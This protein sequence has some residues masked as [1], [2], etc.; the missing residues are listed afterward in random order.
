MALTVVPLSPGCRAGS[1]GGR[2]STFSWENPRGVDSSGG[3][4]RRE[5]AAPLLPKSPGQLLLLLFLPGS[6]HEAPSFPFLQ[7]IPAFI[8]LQAQ[9]CTIQDVPQ[10][11]QV[12]LDSSLT[13]LYHIPLWM[14]Q[15]PSDKCAFYFAS[16]QPVS[17]SLHC[18]CSL[19]Q[20]RPKSHCFASSWIVP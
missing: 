4:G 20:L 9:G 1:S 14:D 5:S 10:P 18:P 15:H 2:E 8:V 11:I 12:L 17:C 13:T 6:R 7:L 16:Q 19:S 3:L